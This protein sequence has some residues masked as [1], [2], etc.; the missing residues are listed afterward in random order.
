MAKRKFTAQEVEQMRQDVRDIFKPFE[1]QPKDPRPLLERKK[2][3][4]LTIA[5]CY[6]VLDAGRDGINEV[7]KNIDK[8]HGAFEALCDLAADYLTKNKEMPEQL[9]AFAAQVL[10]GEIQKPK[11]NFRP[12]NQF[13]NR[14]WLIHKSVG[15]LNQR[16]GLPIYEQDTTTGLTAFSVVCDVL[17][18]CGI[19]GGLGKPMKPASLAKIYS[20]FEKR[21]SAL[22]WGKGGEAGRVEK[23]TST[24]SKT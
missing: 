4:W 1:Q 10:T 23:N 16:Y 21:W 15:L 14:D 22:G 11:L 17:K 24:K 5:T 13:F 6:G 18:A 19:H 2:E 20:D 7:L 3:H 9:R 12:T 8:D